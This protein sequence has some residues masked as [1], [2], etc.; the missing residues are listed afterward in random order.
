MLVLHDKLDIACALS[1][2]VQPMQV[3]YE[4]VSLNTIGKNDC[5]IE[6]SADLNRLNRLD[7]FFLN[8]A[9]VG[10]VLELLLNVVFLL[11]GCIAFSNFLFGIILTVLKLALTFIFKALVELLT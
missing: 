9:D 11:I 8:F 1:R 4:L 7:D 10:K 6:A 3:C 2:F 5:M